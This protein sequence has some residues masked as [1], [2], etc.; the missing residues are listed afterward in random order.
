MTTYKR[1]T[2]CKV[3][4]KITKFRKRKT[5]GKRPSDDIR[6]VTCIDCERRKNPD[7]HW[8]RPPPSKPRVAFE[9]DPTDPDVMRFRTEM[10]KRGA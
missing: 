10:E 8:E 6:I 5:K 1:C 2:S 9:P 3:E 4:K 7:S